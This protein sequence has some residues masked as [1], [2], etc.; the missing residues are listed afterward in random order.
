M[1]TWA[2]NRAAGGEGRVWVKGGG[3]TLW[4]P[5]HGLGPDEHHPSQHQVGATVFTEGTP[6]SV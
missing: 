1:A 2:G 5:A 3:M 4:A 6:N